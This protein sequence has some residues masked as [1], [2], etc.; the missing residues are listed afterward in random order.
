[1]TWNNPKWLSHL[2]GT[3]SNIIG[4]DN[5]SYRI[6][7]GGQRTVSIQYEDYRYKL[8]AGNNR[9]VTLPKDL[10]WQDELAW[11]PVSQ[12]Y[13]YSVEGNLLIQESTKKKG[14]HIT[15][16]GQ[17]NMAWLDRADMLALVAMRD[18]AGLKMLFTFEHKT[19]QSIAPL[20]SYYVMFRHQDTALEYALVKNWDQYE[21]DA[22]YSISAIRLMEVLPNQVTSGV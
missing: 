16:V 10:I 2:D 9:V 14:R 6:P 15:L 7:A 1:M 8:D 4:F 13:E 18:E 12:V 5:D 17:S 3:T 22:F 21:S 20:F 19:N 11:E